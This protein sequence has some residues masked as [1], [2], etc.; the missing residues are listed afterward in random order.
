[1]IKLLVLTHCNPSKFKVADKTISKSSQLSECIVLSIPFLI[2]A[3]GGLLNLSV[4]L[5]H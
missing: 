3:L 2:N 1:M 4:V 5:L